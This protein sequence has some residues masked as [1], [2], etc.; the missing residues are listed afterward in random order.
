MKIKNILICFALLTIASSCINYEK[1]IAEN[2]ADH[3]ASLANVMNDDDCLDQKME[4]WFAKFNQLQA[5][6]YDMDEA[7]EKAI[8][9]VSTEFKDCN[10]KQATHMAAQVDSIEE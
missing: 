8:A 9:A 5:E 1:S 6:G 7:N 4:L 3:N 10:G 2:K